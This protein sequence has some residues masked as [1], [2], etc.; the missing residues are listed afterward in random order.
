[1]AKKTS[2]AATKG[3]CVTPMATGQDI[4]FAQPTIIHAVPP[5]T[6]FWCLEQFLKNL[7]FWS[8]TPDPEPLTGGWLDSIR[9]DIRMKCGSALRSL[10]QYGPDAPLAGKIREAQSLALGLAALLQ[11]HPDLST[12][13]RRQ[14]TVP[15]ERRMFDDLDSLQAEFKELSRPENWTNRGG[16]W[17]L[18]PA[19]DEVLKMATSPSVDIAA[20]QGEGNATGTGMQLFVWL[21]KK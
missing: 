1:M 6:A 20:A 8:I 16:K 2:T 7:L 5:S 10:E 18:N 11:M 9:D 3:E 12:I 13:P 14:W 15:R 17:L 19:A 4:P 21:R